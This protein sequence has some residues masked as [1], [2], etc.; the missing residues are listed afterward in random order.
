[1]RVRVY[2]AL[3]PKICIETQFKEYNLTNYTETDIL[4]QI[5]VLLD[6]DG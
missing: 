6:V 1:M 5:L 2:L 3:I 4:T